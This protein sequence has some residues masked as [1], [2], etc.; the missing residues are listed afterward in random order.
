M[1]AK[2]TRLTHKIAILLHLMAESCTICSSRSRRPV[3]KLLD[4]SSY[5][6]MYIVFSALT[7]R[8]TSLLGNDRSC[9]CY[10]L[11]I[12][13]PPNKLSQSIETRSCSVPFSPHRP[14]IL[15]LPNGIRCFVASWKYLT[16]II[17]NFSQLKSSALLYVLFRFQRFQH[18]NS[19][20]FLVSSEKRESIV[21]I[22]SW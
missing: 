15:D 19:K 21:E 13:V 14:G 4:S 7:T 1:V 16:K 2:L 22:E 8:T 17:L 6:N 20:I 18:N 9:L 10:A 12:Y 11:W 3:R 5:M